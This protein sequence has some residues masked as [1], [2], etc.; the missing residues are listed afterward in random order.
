ML[1]LQTLPE[2]PPLH[3][4][5]SQAGTA[6]CSHSAPGPRMDSAWSLS[7][8][9]PICVCV[10]VRVMLPL[11]P[12]LSRGPAYTRPCTHTLGLGQDPGA[13]A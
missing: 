8:A 4:L 1:V 5:P 9:Q 3:G 2:L 13:P 10:Y 11:L 6:T 7:Q 12:S